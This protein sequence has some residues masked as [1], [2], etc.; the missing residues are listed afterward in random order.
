MNPVARKR[1]VGRII[2]IATGV[3]L[4]AFP[5]IPSARDLAESSRAFGG[6]AE[7]L[8]WGGLLW[9]S[10]ALGPWE[11]LAPLVALWPG[12]DRH[13]PYGIAA[14]ALAISGAGALIYGLIV[15]AL[16]YGLIV[17]FALLAALFGRPDWG[18][19]AGGL[20][21]A[22]FGTWAIRTSRS[23][24]ERALERDREADA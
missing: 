5:L 1:L 2:G 13:N 20:F 7:F 15:P 11:R 12:A 24:Q 22:C 4:L 8:R 21:A 9:L 16:I 3:A 17:P 10:L 23:L 18:P 19:L 6:Y 14:V